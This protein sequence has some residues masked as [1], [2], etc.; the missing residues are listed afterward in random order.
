VIAATPDALAAFYVAD[1]FGLIRA[2]KNAA[3][4]PGRGVFYSRPGREL[5]E[6]RVKNK[7]LGDVRLNG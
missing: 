5:G 4:G 7:D 1:D 3:A 6:C 2:S